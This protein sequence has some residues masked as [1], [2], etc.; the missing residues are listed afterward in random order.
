[1]GNIY[2]QTNET[3]NKVINFMQGADGMLS[4]VE[5]VMTG[6]M[7]TAGLSAATGENGVP[8][9]LL[10][11]NSVVTSM[12]KKYLFTVNAGNNTVSCFAIGGDG[13][14]TLMDTQ[15]TGNALMGKSGTSSTLAYNDADMVLY[16]G[17]SFGPDHIKSF[18]VEGGKLMLTGEAKN[19]NTPEF[20]DRVMTQVLLTPDRKFLL[21]FTVFDAKPTEAGLTPSKGKSVTVFPV[22]DGG[23]LGEAMFRE[24]GGVA[25]FAA[26]FLHGKP[27]MFVTVLAAESGAVLSKIDASGMITSSPIAKIDTMKNGAPA[28]PSEVCWVSISEDDKYA[29]GT[30][31]G[32]GTVSTY[33]IGDGMLKVAASESAMEP[34]DGK[35][36][37]LANIVSSGPGDSVVSGN[38]FYQLYAN[39]SKVVGYMIGADGSL[40]KVTEAAVPYTSSQGLAMI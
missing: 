15:S 9:S 34:G 11:S 7:G 2:T 23:M 3:E 21:A 20:P 14:L 5:R 25:P 32:Y 1:M 31:F 28:E 24:A 19:V 17:H 4:E 40:T 37:G 22:M 12:D 29:F 27:D 39:A 13:R 35:Y 10:S 18:K 6:G 8:D 36:K 38:Y 30:N 16:V 26:A 33:A